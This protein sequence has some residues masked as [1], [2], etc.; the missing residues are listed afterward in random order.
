MS[1]ENE[2]KPKRVLILSASPIRDK[3]I[4]RMIAD[5]LV[6]LGCEV[7]VKP[8]LREGRK[9]VL[10]YQPDVVVTP[11]IRNPYSRDFV[12]TCKD[13]GVGVVSRH[14]EPSC[15]WG[16]YKKLS[17]NQKHEILGRWRYDIDKELVWGADEAEILSR[18]GCGFPVI[19]VGAIGLDI[20]FNKALC[21]SLY[22][23][24]I[25]FEKYKLNPELKTLIISSPWGF[26]DSAPD[27]SIEDI[28]IAQKDI[29]GRGKHLAMIEQVVT[30]LRGKW[31][32]LITVHPGVVVEPYKQLAEKLAVSL[33]ADSPM[34]EMILHC[35]AL[36]HAGSTTA[37]SSHLLNLPAFQ[38][39]DVNCKN[40]DN[41]WGVPESA[42]SRV[43]PKYNDVESLI[44]AIEKAERV[45]NAN[46]ETIKELEKGRYGNM[47]GLAY[48]RAA[49]EISEVGG[50]FNLTWPRSPYDY[51]QPVIFKDGHGKF[52][53]SFCGICNRSFVVVN[54]EWLHRL[55]NT[56]KGDVKIADNLIASCSVCPHCAARF[57]VKA[58][59]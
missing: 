48:Q 18:R 21:E 32:I 44:A 59:N 30:A 53:R 27:L 3:L 31:N 20:Y 23:K 13:Y 9:T 24:K 10:E 46:I 41:W 15:D 54:R 5:E 16:D 12:E 26:A 45:S 17:E 25:F 6:R 42:I 52:D 36:I 33:D 11:P 39:G 38:Y 28:E 58:A 51:D 40:S 49:R 50:K 2:V 14:T 56:M 35:D 34:M 19:P 47:D 4:D 37:I 1:D 57:F 7:Q 29:D 43:S 8:C 55:C 22:D